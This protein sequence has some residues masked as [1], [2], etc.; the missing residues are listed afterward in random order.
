MF[1]RLTEGEDFKSASMYGDFQ[2]TFASLNTDVKPSHEHIHVFGT[3]RD[4]P[5]GVVK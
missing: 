3:G 1:Q 2:N 5:E 4:D